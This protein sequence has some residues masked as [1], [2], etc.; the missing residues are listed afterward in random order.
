MTETAD[1]T[2]A[3]LEEHHWKDRRLISWSIRVVAVAIPLLG[4]A[5]VTMLHFLALDRPE[6]LGARLLFWGGVVLGSIAVALFLERWTRRLLPFAVLLRMSLAFPGEAPNRL[7]VAFREGNAKRLEAQLVDGAISAEASAAQK[8]VS[9]VGLLR[10]HDHKTRGHAERVCAYAELTG[11]ELGLDEAD[12]DKLKWAAL[13][14]D[15]GKLSVPPHVLN[16]DEPPSD[17][18]RQLIR[19]HPVSATAYLGVVSGWLGEWAHAALEHHERWDGE[20]Y[21]S[22]LTGEEIASLDLSQAEWVVLSACQSGRGS[23]VSGEG[24]LGLRRGFEIAGARTLV[25]A[26]W[27]VDDRATRE[28]MVE[29]YRNSLAGGGAAEAVRDASRTV[30]DRRREAGRSDHPFYWAGFVA[31]GDWR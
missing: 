29:L 31:A 11:R 8:L 4:A 9:L 1:A 16:S 30:I 13:I 20:G 15:V 14:H 28:W 26:L 7:L 12:I 6:S 19:N 24:L 22:G 10:H 18:D 25:T 5:G 2:S 3:D 27:R 23:F 21:P 17:D